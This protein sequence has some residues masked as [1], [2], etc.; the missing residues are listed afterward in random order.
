MQQGDVV[1][2]TQRSGDMPAGSIQH[3]HRMNA[4]RQFAGELIEECVHNLGV[5]V[6][7]DQAAG[8]SG[9]RADGAEDIQIVILRLSDR[10]RARADS[11]PHAGDRAVLSET[12]FVLVVDQQTL[13][14]VGRFELIQ[15][16]GHFF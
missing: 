2:D 11:G 8:V 6:R 13:V 3:H 1:R 5:H 7:T 14:G 16:L 12:G 9:F 15:M 4:V 10:P